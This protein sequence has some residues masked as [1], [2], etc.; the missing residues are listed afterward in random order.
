MKK[1]QSKYTLSRGNTVSQF[2]INEFYFVIMVTLEN[3]VPIETVS[4]M[5]GNKCI[6]TTCCSHRDHW[7]N[8]KPAQW[9]GFFVFGLFVSL[10]KVR[11][12]YKIESRLFFLWNDIQQLLQPKQD[13][14]D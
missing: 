10:Y 3:D 1:L 9:R 7:R 13:R 14:K 5:L 12:A 2:N 6:R 8:L 11:F 4:Q